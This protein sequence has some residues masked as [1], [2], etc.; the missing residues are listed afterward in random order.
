MLCSFFEIPV[1]PDL[2]FLAVDLGQLYNTHFLHL[3]RICLFFFTMGRWTEP[4]Y[5]GELVRK[6]RTI[7]D[8]IVTR[9]N[10]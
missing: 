1:T 5:D 2:S 8:D 3:K 9:N 4:N 10:V 7:F 6:F